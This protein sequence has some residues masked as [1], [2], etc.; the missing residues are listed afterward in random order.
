M[1]GGSLDIQSEKDKGSIIS[2][3]LP[4]DNKMNPENSQTHLL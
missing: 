2:I 3:I 4:A 1:T